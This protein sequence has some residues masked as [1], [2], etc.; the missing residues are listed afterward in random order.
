MFD[1]TDF[2]P[3][4]CSSSWFSFVPINVG[5]GRNIWI[6]IDRELVRESLIG[7]DDL[8]EKWEASNELRRNIMPRIEAAHIGPLPLSKFVRVLVYENG[9]WRERVDW[10]SGNAV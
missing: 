1:F 5:S 3:A 6:E 9:V 8:V 10:K 2:D 4:K 7:P